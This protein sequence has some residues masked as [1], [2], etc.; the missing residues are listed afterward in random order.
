MAGCHNPRRSKLPTKTA[1]LSNEREISLLCTGVCA[2]CGLFSY[3]W[4]FSLRQSSSALTSHYKIGF[5]GVNVNPIVLR[6]FGVI[7]G[8]FYLFSRPEGKNM[9]YVR[10]S[11]SGESSRSCRRNLAQNRFLV[12]RRSSTVMAPGAFCFPGGGI[13]SGETE[14]IALVRELQEELAVQ[15]KPVRRIWR[16]IT[17]EKSNWPGGW[18]ISARPYRRQI[19]RR[20]PMSTGGQHMRCGNAVRSCSRVIAIFYGNFVRGPFASSKVLSR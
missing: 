18:P 14:E 10:K 17:D 15:S 19:L 16:N 13:E 6:S 9:G 3:S 5:G 4:L 8:R 12:I 11:G 2:G 7:L 20:S 1:K